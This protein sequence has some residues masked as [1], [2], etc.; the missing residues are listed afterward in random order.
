MKNIL[1]FLFTLFA[2][3]QLKAQE[4]TVQACGNGSSST[5]EIIKG[6]DYIYRFV[7]KK[8]KPKEGLQKFYEE[9]ANEFVKPKLSDD[10]NQIKIRLR[11]VVEK[12]GSFSDIQIID[13]KLNVGEEAMRVLKKMKNWEPAEYEGQI[14]RMY[15]IL[16]INIAVN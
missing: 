10:I 13:D 11:F 6:E 7:N 12:D 16:P 3:M 9:F 8:A 14:V 4:K 5:T 1:M 2:L 15:F